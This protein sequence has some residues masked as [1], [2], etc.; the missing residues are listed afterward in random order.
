[1]VLM[2]P[3]LEG[4]LMEMGSGNSN[5]Q[6]KIQL[7][8]PQALCDALDIFVFFKRARMVTALPRTTGKITTALLRAMCCGPRRGVRVASARSALA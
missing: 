8:S 1:M 4:L 5:T 7:L 3:T 2:Y 6:L